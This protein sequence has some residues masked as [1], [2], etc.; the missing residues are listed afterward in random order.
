MCVKM[1]NAPV[2]NNNV[3]QAIG[4]APQGPAA[5]VMN[6]PVINQTSSSDNK[7]PSCGA[8][9]TFD[10]KTGGLVCNFCGNTVQLNSAPAEPGT[11]YTFDDFINN[12]AHRLT[13]SS[14]KL[15]VCGTCGG[16]FTADQKSISGLCPFCG[17]N[18]ITISNNDM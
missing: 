18:S 7:C 2:Y 4:T 14:I 9:L 3:G 11:G 13:D 10:P 12:S 8:T 5:P 16:H 17:S 1:G 15:I 6:V